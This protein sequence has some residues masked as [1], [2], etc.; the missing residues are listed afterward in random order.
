MSKH[1]ASRVKLITSWRER[2][3][4]LGGAISPRYPRHS[5]ELFY[6]SICAVVGRNSIGYRP[7]IEK[8]AAT[9]PLPAKAL[10]LVMED[11]A[12]DGPWS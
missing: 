9:H 6:C 11:P 5:D 3:V 8:H 10:P 4:A 12:S 1:L 2:T 7:E